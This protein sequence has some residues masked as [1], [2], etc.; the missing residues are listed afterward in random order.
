MKAM[1]D[2]AE[3]PWPS[4]HHY[5]RERA[6]GFVFWDNNYSKITVLPLGS[7]HVL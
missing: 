1:E 4:N 7:A 2:L 3:D 6:N 5:R